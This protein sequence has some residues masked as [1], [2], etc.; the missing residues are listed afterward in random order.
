[1]PPS[2][3]RREQ[4]ARMWQALVSKAMNRQTITYRLLNEVIGLGPGHLRGIGTT[5]DIL[6]DYCAAKGYPCLTVLVVSASTGQPQASAHYVPDDYVE[7]E[8]VYGFNWFAVRPPT[9]DELK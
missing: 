6:A 8:K 1:M 9:L 2:Q 7:H 5:L 3:S 4:A